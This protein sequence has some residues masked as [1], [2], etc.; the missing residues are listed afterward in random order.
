MPPADVETASDSLPQGSC[1]RIQVLV[2]GRHKRWRDEVS[3]QVRML[4]YQVTAC[5]RGVDAMT[6]LALGLPVDVLVVDTALHGSLCCAQLAV[7]ARTLRPGLRI[8]LARDP[9][10]AMGPEVS[11]RVPDALLV[12]RDQLQNGMVATTMREALASRAA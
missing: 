7:E 6:V 11:A 3:A 5:D 12:P 1:Y 9:V 8:I 2:V 10:D 4:G